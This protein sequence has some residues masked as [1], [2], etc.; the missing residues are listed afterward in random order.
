[1][2]NKKIKVYFN[3][4][5]REKN[6]KGEQE[7][8]LNLYHNHDTVSIPICLWIHPNNWNEVV[9]KAKGSGFQIACVNRQLNEHLQRIKDIILELEETEVDV[10][11]TMIIDNFIN[12]ESHLTLLNL[13]KRHIRM[14]EANETHPFSKHTIRHY[15]LV[16]NKL[17]EFLSSSH[18]KVRD[19]NLEKIDLSFIKNFEEFLMSE[20]NNNQNTI[21]K[22]MNKLK[23]FIH[24]GMKLKWIQCDPFFDYKTTFIKPE[25]DFLDK[26]EVRRI[27]N[28]SFLG[29]KYLELS[30]DV[31][32]FMV[33]TGICFSDVKRLTV[34]NI[35]ISST[36][37]Y[38]ITYNRIKN[39]NLGRVPIISKVAAIIKKYSNDPDCKNEY[40]LLPR[41]ASQT[42]NEYLKEICLLANIKKPVTCHTARYTFTTLVRTIGNLQI[43]VAADMLAHSSLE[44]TS[45]YSKIS[46]LPVESYISNIE[47]T[48]EF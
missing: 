1:M 27:Q 43:E 35:T 39:G 45:G 7:I 32:L 21:Y 48:F 29:N 19:I 14:M 28:L 41:I 34:F 15:R 23:A 8:Q 30:K 13:V 4:N 12:R 25:R 22:N 36:G 37:V 40:F 24:T 47:K 26:Y 38:I 44:G 11:L 20:Y 10:S 42:V 31:F 16:K 5:P 46:L 17:E 9:Q 3:L 33:Y 6:T 2:I 18:Y